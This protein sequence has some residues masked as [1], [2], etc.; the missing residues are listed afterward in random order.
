MRALN[1]AWVDMLCCDAVQTSPLCLPKRFRASIYLVPLSHMSHR[2]FSLRDED[3][4]Q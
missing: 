4:V 3:V 1:E 2:L